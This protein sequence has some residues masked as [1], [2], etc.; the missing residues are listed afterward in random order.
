M[1][2]GLSVGHKIT[3]LLSFSTRPLLSFTLALYFGAGA[4][5]EHAWQRT[6]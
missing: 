5:C 3:F 1:F 6:H 2:I 4:I